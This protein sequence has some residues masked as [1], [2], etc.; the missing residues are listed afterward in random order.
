MSRRVKYE[1]C[2]EEY[3]LTSSQFLVLGILSAQKDTWCKL[4]YVELGLIITRMGIDLWGGAGSSR[5]QLH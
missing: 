3:L 4:G 1:A 5:H 2:R